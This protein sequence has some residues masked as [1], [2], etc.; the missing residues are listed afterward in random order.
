MF[1]KARFETSR[2]FL[3]LVFAMALF[4]PQSASAQWALEGR[5]GAATPAGDLTDQLGPQQTGFGA[6]GTLMYGFNEMVTA[7]GGA[8]GQWFTCEGCDTDVLN[9]ASTEA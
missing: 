3:A 2:L 5:A 6:A 7:Y 1:E 4:N 8:G 9:G